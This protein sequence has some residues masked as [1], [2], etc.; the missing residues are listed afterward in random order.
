MLSRRTARRTLRD[1]DC[2]PLSSFRLQFEIKERLKTPEMLEERRKEKESRIAEATRE[3]RPPPAATPPPSPSEAPESAATPSP[4]DAPDA[5]SRPSVPRLEAVLTRKHEWESRAKKASNRSWHPLFLVL[6]E[7]Q[8][9]AYKDERHARERPTEHYHH[10]APLEL[11]G[12][13]AA[14]ASDYAKRPQVLRLKLTNG[15][16]YL[17]QCRSAE[18]MNEWSAALNAH[19]TAGGAAAGTSSRSATLPAGEGASAGPSGGPAGK[20]KFFTL[21]RK[22]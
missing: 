14:P 1:R 15:A 10:E 18:E 20:K 13:S 8:L 2:E 11:R 6:A 22:K 21:G 17:F 3:F 19:A 9:A 16:E 12:A 4:L 5:P 7:G